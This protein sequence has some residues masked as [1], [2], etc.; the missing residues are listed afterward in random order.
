MENVTVAGTVKDVNGEPIIGANV[1]VSG[2]TV[3]TI[4]DIDGK[5][6]LT[7]P[8]AQ[9]TKRSGYVRIGSSRRTAA[10]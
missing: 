1:L 10:I 2:S 4:T 9:R 3:G 5:F 7:A 6:S 8:A